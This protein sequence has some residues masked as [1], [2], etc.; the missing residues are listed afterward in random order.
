LLWS[1]WVSCFAPMY[2]SCVLEVILIL[3]V[4]RVR[5]KVTLDSPQS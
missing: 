1:L 2:T 4:I 5:D 3:F